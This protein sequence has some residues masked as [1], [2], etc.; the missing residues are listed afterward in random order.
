MSSE[1]LIFFFFFF[2]VTNV[3]VGLFAREREGVTLKTSWSCG[4]E[5]VKVKG[6]ASY[7]WKDMSCN[8]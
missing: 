8:E 2:D 6:D 3:F 1:K 4:A 7:Y 5:W